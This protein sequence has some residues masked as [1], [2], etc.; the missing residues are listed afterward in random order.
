MLYF[1][2]CLNQCYGWTMYL[3]DWKGF[4]IVWIPQCLSIL[5]WSCLELSEHFMLS[6]GGP[7]FCS[8]K[9]P[10][11]TWHPF[12]RAGFGCRSF[13]RVTFKRLLSM[14][15]MCLLWCLF[16]YRVTGTRVRNICTRLTVTE[17]TPKSKRYN[18]LKSGVSYPLV[19]SVSIRC[20]TT[21]ISEIRS[22]LKK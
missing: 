6:L 12:R 15:A 18:T 1:W 7:L 8:A 4:R 2:R 3:R 14:W 16:V 21:E 11:E 20:C 17:L 10:N 5:S 13:A 9:A 19:F 22:G